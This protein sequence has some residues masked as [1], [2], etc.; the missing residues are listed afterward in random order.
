MSTQQPLLTDRRILI[1][2]SGGIAA[3][4]IAELI[5]LLREQGA[6]CRVVMTQAATQFITPLT[7]QALSG[8]PVHLQ[9]FDPEQEQSM[10]HIELARWADLILVAPSTANTIA[11]ISHGIADDL[12]TTTL[13]ASSAAKIIA[14]AMNSQMWSA[15]ATQRNLDQLRLD[16]Y[17]IIDPESGALACGESGMGRMA[18]PATL[19]QSAIDHF[20][21]GPLLG[22][23]IT[24][25]AGPTRE[26]IDPVRYITN[27]SSGKMGFAIA[28]AAQQLGATVRLVSG[29]VQ[30]QTP[31]GVERIDVESAEQMLAA[32]LQAPGDIFIGCAAVADY[33]CEQ[34]MGSKIKKESERTQLSL[35]Q[36]PDILHRVAQLPSPPFTVGFAAETDELERYALD[37]LERK[38]ID[39]IAANWV[40]RPEGGFESN[41]NSLH[42]FWKGGEQ[43][44]PFGPKPELAAQLMEII[45]QQYE[46]QST[47][48]QPSS[49]DSGT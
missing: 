25:T 27:R 24:I 49:S 15:P 33:R 38:Q 32:V 16:G 26:A 14:P 41:D 7:L 23:R 12:L 13:L 6:H 40:G 30:Q 9:L 37:K 3:Y 35:M 29:P 2:V 36:N 44:L 47:S 48:N 42:L 34:V 19:L 4:K 43:M 10:G 1:G 46:I 18:A 22:R 11:K 31:R 8:N 39:L 20:R 5:R 21:S 45:T 17:Q 28:S